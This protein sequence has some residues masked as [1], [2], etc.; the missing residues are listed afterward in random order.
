[1][2]DRQQ[3]EE[4]RQRLETQKEHV[5]GEMAAH[6]PSSDPIG[7]VEEKADRA[8]SNYVETRITANDEALLE[9]IDFALGRLASGTYEQCAHC[10]GNIP[11][12]RLM[13]KPSVSLCLSCQEKKDSGQLPS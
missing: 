7:D 6:Q 13:A 1:M 8:A 11:V 10:G 5:L 12:E 2:M 9:K 3:F 4:I